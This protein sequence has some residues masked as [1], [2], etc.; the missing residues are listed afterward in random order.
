MPRTSKI[1]LRKSKGELRSWRRLERKRWD[2]LEEKECDYHFDIAA[3]SLYYLRLQMLE[4]LASFD[5]EK[6]R[7]TF[8]GLCEVS[9]G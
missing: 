6:G 3:L 4:R 9:Y 8:G 7:E 2:F 5:K 1:R